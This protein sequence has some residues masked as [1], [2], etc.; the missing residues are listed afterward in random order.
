ML[1]VVADS[2]EELASALEIARPM[3]DI[4]FFV[5]L[6]YPNNRPRVGVHH[7]SLVCLGGDTPSYHPVTKKPGVCPSPQGLLRDAHQ[8]VCLSAMPTNNMTAHVD[9]K[10]GSSG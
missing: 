4:H 1:F 2:V 3:S 10:A 6:F 9:L 5:F 8:H 7:N